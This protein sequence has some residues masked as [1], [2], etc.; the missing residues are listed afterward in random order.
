MENSLE[1]PQN[2]KHIVT[3]STSS[4]PRHISKKISKRNMCPYR[5]LYMHAHSIITQN[6]QKMEDN[7]NVYQPMTEWTLMCDTTMECYVTHATT[8]WILKILYWV[9]EAHHIQPYITWFNLHELSRTGKSKDRKISDH[10]GLMEE[11]I[12]SG[13]WGLR[14]FSLEAMKYSGIRWRW[15]LHKHVHILKKTEF[16]TLKWWIWAQRFFRV[17]TLLLLH[18]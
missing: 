10:Q 12:E 1:I 3:W 17:V 5:N 14:S 2:A 9:K 6:S 15:S 16:Y 8:Q 13:C 7:P 11:G 18:Y 4:T